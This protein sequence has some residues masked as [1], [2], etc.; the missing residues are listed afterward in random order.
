M[1]S[2]AYYTDA[3]FKQKANFDLAND[4][5]GTKNLDI[6]NNGLPSLFA[7]IAQNAII[8]YN[9][10]MNWEKPTSYQSIVKAI[11]K[12]AKDNGS[13]VLVNVSG[14]EDNQKY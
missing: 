5:L 7:F 3:F 12:Y 11:E 10:I 9:A 8:S 2:Y 1:P 4:P 14:D 6:I 13:L